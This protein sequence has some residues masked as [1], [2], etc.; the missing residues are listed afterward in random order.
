[1][2]RFNELLQAELLPVTQRSRSLILPVGIYVRHGNQISKRIL[3]RLVCCWE[4]KLARAIAVSGRKCCSGKGWT[5]KTVRE[6]Q[7][8]VG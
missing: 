8:M 2:N 5:V 1:M 7:R 6:K 3:K 4:K